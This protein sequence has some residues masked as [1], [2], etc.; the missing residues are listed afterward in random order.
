MGIKQATAP[1]YSPE[2]EALI[3][4]AADAGPF[5]YA[6][7]TALAEKMG[8][9]PKSVT[10][11]AIRMGV[12]YVRKAPVTKTGAPVIRKKDIVA[13]IAAMC[14]GNLAGLEDAPKAALEAIRDR[15]DFLT[16]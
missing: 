3:Q 7:A 9:N 16:D 15:L 2:Q 4:A 14:P 5:D 8:K 1:N 11:K 6:V 10:A 12:P 13:E